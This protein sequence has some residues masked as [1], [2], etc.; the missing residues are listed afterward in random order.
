M[1]KNRLNSLLRSSGKGPLSVN[2]FDNSEAEVFAAYIF[3]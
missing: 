3:S 1:D 2:T